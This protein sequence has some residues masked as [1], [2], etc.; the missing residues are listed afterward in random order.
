[1][2]LEARVTVERQR[3]DSEFFAPSPPR[4]YSTSSL[5]SWNSPESWIW[6]AFLTFLITV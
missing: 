3:V 5:N 1:M 4:M 6:C 2:H